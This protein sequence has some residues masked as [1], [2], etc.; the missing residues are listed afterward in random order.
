LLAI[1]LVLVFSRTKVFNIWISSLDYGRAFLVFFAIT[2]S[3]C[4]LKRRRRGLTSFPLGLPTAA[5]G[6]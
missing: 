4:E 6:G 1:A 5:D 3:L 2:V